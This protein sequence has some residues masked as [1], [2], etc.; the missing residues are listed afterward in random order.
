MSTIKTTVTA[1]GRL[2]VTFPGN[3]GSFTDDPRAYPDNIFWRLAA[4]GLREKFTN[5]AS[6]SKDPTS[7]KPATAQAKY[8]SLMEVR[9]AL[10]NG[11][12]DRRGGGIT[13]DDTLLIDAIV[14]SHGM[15]RDAVRTAVLGWTRDQRMA[16]QAEEVT[17]PVFERMKK[18][19]DERVA[20]GVN[21]A[22]LFASIGK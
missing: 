17:A 22:N 7:G 20:F 10:R 16:A 11:D 21:V 5:A 14:E 4:Y 12:W 9:A 15:E 2:T 1:D 18:E 19:R 13:S 3:L 8:D 6:L